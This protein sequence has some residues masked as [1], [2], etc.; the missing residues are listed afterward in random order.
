MERRAFVRTTLSL[1]GGTVMA[2]SAAAC[3]ASAFPPEGVDTPGLLASMGPERI[4]RIGRAYLAAVPSERTPELLRSAIRNDLAPWPW[5]TPVSVPARVADDFAQYRTVQ[6]DGWMLSVT[7][8][9]QCALYT[10]INS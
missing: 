10:L 6:A 2:G 8:A 7:E 9:R 3:G 4:A 1:A 5:S